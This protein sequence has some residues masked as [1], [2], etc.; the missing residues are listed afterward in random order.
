MKHFIA[1]SILMAFAVAAFAND[2]DHD[3]KE[4]AFNILKTKCNSCHVKMNPFRVFNRNNM[5]R[6][7]PA[8]YEEVFVKGRMPLG[9]E[10]KL[11]EEER[12]TLKSWLVA[13]QRR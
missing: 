2:N 6:H 3:A 7:A 8:I 4:K 1:L 12:Q 9:D 11:S 13:Q 5:M 10:V